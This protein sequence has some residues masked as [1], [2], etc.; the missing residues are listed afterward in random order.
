VAIFIVEEK[1]SQAVKALDIHSTWS[2]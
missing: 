2:F 1:L